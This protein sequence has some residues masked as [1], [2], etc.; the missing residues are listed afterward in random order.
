MPLLTAFH[1]RSEHAGHLSACCL[2]L[3]LAYLSS[4]CVSIFHRSLGPLLHI[5][6]PIG[7]ATYLECK[8]IHAQEL[9]A[10]CRIGWVTPPAKLAYFR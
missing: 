5:V 8:N 3:V 7:L 9:G 4:E 1:V 6:F 2:H 10:R